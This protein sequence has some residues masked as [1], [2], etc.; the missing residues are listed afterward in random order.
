MAKRSAT[1]VGVILVV[2]A[3][4]VISAVCRTVC[5]ELYTVAPQQME[6]TLLAGDRVVVRSDMFIRIVE[7]GSAC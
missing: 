7:S 2:V 5:V 6:N 3:A 1:I 4:V